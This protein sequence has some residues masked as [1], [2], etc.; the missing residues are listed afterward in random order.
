MAVAE[1]STPPSTLPAVHGGAP[2]PPQHSGEAVTPTTNVDDDAQDY[3]QQMFEELPK[4]FVH[5]ILCCRVPIN[6]FLHS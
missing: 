5:P 6:L 3:A 1:V 4:R 2:P